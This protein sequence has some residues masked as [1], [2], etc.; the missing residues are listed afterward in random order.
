MHRRDFADAETLFSEALEASPI[1]ERA[2][3]GYAETLWKRDERAEAIK[4]MNEAVRLSGSNPEYMIRLGEMYL[5]VDEI[6]QAVAQAQFALE[7]DHRSAAAWALLGNARTA[8][9]QWE[10]AIDCF[11]RALL[12]QRDYPAVQLAVAKNYRV[13]GRSQRSL[14]TL[15]RM[16]D[17]HPTELTDPHLLLVR[18]LALSDLGRE[19]EAI[20]SLSQA[21]S[22]LPLAMKDEH[23]QLAQAQ[24]RLGDLVQSR[25]TLGRIIQEFPTDLAARQLQS[26][27]DSSFERVAQENLFPDGKIYR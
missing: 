6:D 12:I 1:D 11:H 3:A 19:Q 10:P 17:L 16:I 22:R 9:Q 8:R 7:S 14:A 13:I 24:Y 21:A 25:L 26:N 23:L 18:G 4:H 27:L 2:Q 20:A 5:E 15:D